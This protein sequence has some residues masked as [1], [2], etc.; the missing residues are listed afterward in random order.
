MFF[1][2]E[3]KK[4]QINQM[5]AIHPDLQAVTFPVVELL[6]CDVLLMDN[7]YYPWL[8]LVPHR[9][10]MKEIIDL[11]EIDQQQLMREITAVSKEMKAIFAPDKINVASLGNH[12]DQLHIHI[13]GRYKDDHAWPHPV[14]EKGFTPYEPRIKEMML[15]RLA[16]IVALGKQAA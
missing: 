6:L 14:W 16:P 9:N 12:V 15:E 3:N 7:A 13:I 1:H 2:S 10:G 5:F 11:D 4:D 8:L